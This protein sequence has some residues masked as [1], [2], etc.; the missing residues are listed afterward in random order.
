MRINMHKDLRNRIKLGCERG[1]TLVEAAV[2]VLLLGGVVLTMVLC[3]SGG[4]L[5]ARVQDEQATAQGLAR[6]QMEYIKRYTYNPSATTYP[7]ITAPSGYSINV[8]V[9]SVPDTDT[10][11]QK[12]TVFI[13]RN[14]ET[15][16]TLQD[17]K[18]N[19]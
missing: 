1:V 15:L 9:G 3:L 10:N 18:E 5:G 2:A 7:K 11:I 17:Y 16:L 19:R 4:A 14:G 13:I 8:T 12:I 6:S